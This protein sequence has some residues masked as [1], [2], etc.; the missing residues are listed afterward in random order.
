MVSGL[1]V[2]GLILL[3]IL[4]RARKAVGAV[5][6]S[7]LGGAAA[8]T[9]VNLTGLITGVV[10]PLNVFSLLVCCLLG[11]PG[12]ISLLVLQLFW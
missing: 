9:A 11:A 10:L 3:V 4:I 6:L 7:A 5:A 8:M 2:G 1:L 12:V